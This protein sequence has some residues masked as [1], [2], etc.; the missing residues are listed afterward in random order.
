VDHVSFEGRVQLLP[1]V[2]DKLRTSVGDYSVW[3]SV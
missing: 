1:K 2:S 3:N